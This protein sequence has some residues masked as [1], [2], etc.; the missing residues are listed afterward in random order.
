MALRLAAALNNTSPEFWLRVRD[1]H[2]L[3]RAKNKVDTKNVTVFW[4][5]AVL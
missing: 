2:D 3:F 4:K 5:A 1:N